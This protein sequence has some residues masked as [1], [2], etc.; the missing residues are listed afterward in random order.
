MSSEGSERRSRV[1][2][3]VRSRGD[4]SARRA[5]GQE[6]G[7]HG[8]TRPCA[9]VLDLG[10]PSLTRLDSAWGHT[11]YCSAQILLVEHRGYEY[12]RGS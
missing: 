1:D 11:Q 2:E 9:A 3:M 4:R 8:R 7:R 10:A 6:E 5:D 12:T